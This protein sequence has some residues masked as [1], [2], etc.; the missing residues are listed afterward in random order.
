MEQS[1]VSDDPVCPAC[2]SAPLK[3]AEI[4]PTELKK[5]EF[6]GERLA[7][8]MLLKRIGTWALGDTYLAIDEPQN[9]LAEVRVVSRDHSE[10]EAFFARLVSDFR[11]LHREEAPKHENL[12]EFYGLRITGRLAFAASERVNGCTIHRWMELVGPLSLGDSLLITAKCAVVLKYLHARSLVLRNLSPDSITITDDGEVKVEDVAVAVLTNASSSH[13]SRILRPADIACA[14]P[15]ELLSHKAD[16]R[17]DVFSLGCTLFHMLTGDWP[18]PLGPIEDLVITRVA[19][20]PDSV[21][22][23]NS[24]IP[25]EVDRLISRMIK[26]TPGD[27]IRNCDEVLREIKRIGLSNEKPAL[28]RR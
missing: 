6:E 12:A 25:V 16:A 20:A 11:T 18:W 27:R 4:Q 22:A 8:F 21:R 5:T 3:A 19:V 17:S 1:S 9:R 24:K 13:G 7:E 14:A 26:P 10:D 23:H 28:T 2:G 15:E